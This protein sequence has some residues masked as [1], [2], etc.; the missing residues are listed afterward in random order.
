M[1]F[2]GNLQAATVLADQTDIIQDRER[3]EIY[4]EYLADKGNLQNEYR[5]KAK[6]V[7]VTSNFS[8]ITH[9][10]TNFRDVNE[11]VDKLFLQA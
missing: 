3:H 6:Q 8:S 10:L 9:I 11:S 5:Q 7:K 4:L 1:V 2:I